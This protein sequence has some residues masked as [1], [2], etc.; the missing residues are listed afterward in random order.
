MHPLTTPVADKDEE[1]GERDE[2]ANSTGTEKEAEESAVEIST[3]PVGEAQELSEAEEV[4]NRM[5]TH[6]TLTEYVNDLQ[7]FHVYNSYINSHSPRESCKR[8][9]YS[10]SDGICEDRET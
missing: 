10:A 3:D 2:K 1:K 9:K 4:G 6:T 7:W 5:Y 8:T